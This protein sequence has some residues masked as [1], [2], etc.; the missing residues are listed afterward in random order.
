[1]IILVNSK[2][3]S[4]QTM[5]L[6]HNQRTLWFKCVSCDYFI[7][8]TYQE[9]HKYDLQKKTRVPSKHGPFDSK[10]V[11]PLAC[12]GYEEHHKNMER[13]AEDISKCILHALFGSKPL[14]A[15][16]GLI[17]CDF[18]FTDEHEFSTFLY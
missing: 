11:H 6:L 16:H 18:V 10:A 3:Y 14:Q 17:S 2:R 9:S 8:Y 1:M 13:M 5:V 4:L 7:F 15:F 12:P